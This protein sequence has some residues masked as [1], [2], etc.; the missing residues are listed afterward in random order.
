MLIPHRNGDPACSPGHGELPHAGQEAVL[1]SGRPD[2]A[3]L[4]GISDGKISGS[5]DSNNRVDR[6]PCRLPRRRSRGRAGS[7]RAQGRPLGARTGLRVCCE[8]KKSWSEGREER[9]G[10]T[11]C[12]QGGRF[13]ANG[14]RLQVRFPRTARRDAAAGERREVMLWGTGRQ[15]RQ[16]KVVLW[17]TGREDSEKGV[18]SGSHRPQGIVSGPGG[19]QGRQPKVMLW[20][21]GRQGR[22]RKGCVFGRLLGPCPGPE[23]PCGGGPGRRTPRTSRTRTNA[24]G[25]IGPN[26]P[27]C[28]YRGSTRRAPCT[29]RGG[30]GCGADSAACARTRSRWRGRGDWLD[31]D[32]SPETGSAHGRAG[33]CLCWRDTAPLVH[34]QG[35]LPFCRRNR[36]DQH[37]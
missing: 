32:R 36:P 15:G 2:Q 10:A 28:R 7:C 14:T 12:P 18:F 33:L 11:G 27:L 29:P 30:A 25:L 37:Q 26:R 23:H 20:G 3:G 16:P 35:E 17:G 24:A 22:Q 5:G 4:C 6:R 8:T 21:T 31:A 19:R 13:R 1:F 34:S 9:P